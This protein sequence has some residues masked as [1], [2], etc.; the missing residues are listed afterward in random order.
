MGLHGAMPG[1][2]LFSALLLLINLGGGLAGL[3]LF[4]VLPILRTR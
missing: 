4:Y 3:V 2:L 1:Q